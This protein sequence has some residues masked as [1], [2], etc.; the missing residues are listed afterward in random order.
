MIRQGPCDG[1]RNL[2]TSRLPGTN[3]ASMSAHWRFGTSEKLRDGAGQFA[4]AMLPTW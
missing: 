2:A 3:P 1:P 4:L